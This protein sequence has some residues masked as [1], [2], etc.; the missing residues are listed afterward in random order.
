MRPQ[1]QKTM[2]AAVTLAVLFLLG[3]MFIAP[4]SVIEA[5]PTLP[6]R[7]P[8][9][10]P[11]PQRDDN[12]NSAPIGATILLQNAPTGVWSAV[13]WQ[14]AN[15]DWQTVEGWQGAVD[16]NGAKQWWVAQKDFGS[17]PFRWLVGDAA[18]ESFTL[19]AEANSTLIVAAP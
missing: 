2:I 1:F 10:T 14:D 9:A 5:G 3:L 12:R 13:Q 4:L 15:G 8:T 6:P 18:S 16:A 19:P 7:E 17:G 11:Q